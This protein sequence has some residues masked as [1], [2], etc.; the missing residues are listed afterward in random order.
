MIAK[1]VESVEHRTFPDPKDIMTA[2]Q[3]RETADEN[4]KTMWGE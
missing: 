2:A 3:F 4:V 1:R